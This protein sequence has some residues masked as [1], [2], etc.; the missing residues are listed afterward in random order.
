MVKLQLSKFLGKGILDLLLFLIRKPQKQALKLAWLIL[1]VKPTYT[2]VSTKRLINLYPLVRE[3][4]ALSL[5]GDIVECGV[6][7]GGSAAIMGM[8]CLDDQ[9]RNPM[10]NLWLFDSFRGLPPPGERDEKRARDSYF[11]GWC[12]GDVEKVVKIFHRLGVPLENV[13]IIEGWF[14][15]K[16]AATDIK[17]IALLHID[18][19]WYESVKVVLE[20]LY[21]RV[22]EEGFIVL[23][24]YWTWSG[25][26]AAVE[27]YLREKR[28]EGVVMK[29]VDRHGT[30]FQK[31]LQKRGCTSPGACH[32]PR[33]IHS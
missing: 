6:W 4:N 1:Q 17:A 20:K 8:A 9:N 3:A 26:Q 12:K 22:V 18:V 32:A 25:C 27:D 2:M 23:D 33:P 16:L 7:N 14:D 29:S 31:P 13:K 10:R 24:D 28:I 5:P 11:E 15:S 30:Y 19:D 21:D